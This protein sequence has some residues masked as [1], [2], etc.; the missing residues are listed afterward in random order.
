MKSYKI[1]EDLSSS[2]ERVSP[3]WGVSK[4]MSINLAWLKMLTK[5]VEDCKEK[6]NLLPVLCLEGDAHKIRPLEDFP[7]PNDCDILYYG[8]S[9]GGPGEWMNESYSQVDGFPHLV[10]VNKMAQMH[11]V[12]FWNLDAVKQ[13]REYTA[14]ALCNELILDFVWSQEFLKKFNTYALKKPVFV[15]GTSQQ[16]NA[17]YNIT[18]IVFV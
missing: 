13:A 17:Y 5:I 6:P 2:Y 9:S 8:I 14:A 4:G 10:R 11:A 15:Q 7:V 1:T 3:V 12:S 18:N 16:D